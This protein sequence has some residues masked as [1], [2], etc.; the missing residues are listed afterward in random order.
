MVAR[1]PPQA[2]ASLARVATTATPAGA[3][4]KA[5]AAVLRPGAAPMG[6]FG[7]L[8]P[9]PMAQMTAGSA[10]RQ[11]MRLPLAAMRPQG[12]LPASLTIGNPSGTMAQRPPG[13]LPGVQGMAQAAFAA[14]TTPPRMGAAGGSPPRPPIPSQPQERPAFFMPGVMQPVYRPA[15]GPIKPWATGG[16]PATAHAPMPGGQQRPSLFGPPPSGQPGPP[17]GAAMSQGQPRPSLFSPMPPGQSRPSIDG[18]HQHPQGMGGSAW[19]TAGHLAGRLSSA[20]PH[21]TASAEIVAGVAGAA[22]QLASAL[23]AASAGRLGA[24]TPAV[25]QAA[26]AVAGTAAT[27][28]AFGG[29]LSG[30]GQLG[31]QLSAL[32]ASLFSSSRPARVKVSTLA[33][34]YN[35]QPMS[36]KLD[37][38]DIQAYVQAGGRPDVQAYLAN[39]IGRQGQD[40]HAPKLDV[41]GFAVGLGGKKVSEMVMDWHGAQHSFDKLAKGA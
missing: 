37:Q 32:K 19:Q 27:A 31:S 28:A 40:P 29:S 30:L 13:K 15:D 14:S 36:L 8:A 18:H 33:G 5:G 35:G 7:A 34:S 16:S 10:P 12:P 11:Q 1:I 25:A 26:N 17:F 2:A 4:A 23:P 39:R 22:G 41:G 3:A 6:P 24:V 20:L 9:R 21:L 38:R